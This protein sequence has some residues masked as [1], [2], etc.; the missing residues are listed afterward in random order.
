MTALGRPRRVLLGAALALACTAGALLPLTEAASTPA[1]AADE[2][3]TPGVIGR[4]PGPPPVLTALDAEPG[5]LG[6][7]GRGILVAIVDSG[8]DGTRPQLAAALAPGSTSLVDDGERPDGLGDPFGHGTAIAGIIAARAEAGSGVTGLAPD[9]EIVSIRVFSSTDEQAKKDG[10]GPTADRLAAGIREAGKLGAKIIVVAMSDDV[11]SEALRSATADAVSAGALIVASG[12]NRAT[13]ASAADSPRYPAA[14]PG[15]LSVTATTLTGIPTDDSIHGEHIDV[16]APGQNVL[17]TATGAGDCTY[18]A[19]A[20]SSSFSTAYAAGAA[21]LIAEAHPDETPAE[22]I[23]RLQATAER[24]NPDARDDLIG[25]G[26]IRPAAA[27]ALRPDSSTRGPASPFTDTSGAGITPP[28]TQIAPSSAPTANHVPAIIGGATVCGVIA[29]GALIAQVRRRSAAGTAGDDA[30]A[31]DA[32]GTDTSGTGAT[33]PAGAGAHSAD[34]GGGSEDDAD[35][36]RQEPIPP[37]ALAGRRE[38]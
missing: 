6:Y 20:P 17:T 35:G 36:E 32:N 3:C 1:H 9:A 19:D 16:A 7:T 4:V 5:T 25:W 31:A 10:T 33:G 24:P 12:G 22:W 37:G 14:Y 8:V 29:I 30:S 34:G 2:A 23:Y 11:D 26:R 18:A 38:Y 13:T 15:T 28:R 21:A 27:I